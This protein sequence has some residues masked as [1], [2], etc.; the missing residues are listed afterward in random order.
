M[1]V[2]YT[3]KI[4]SNRSLRSSDAKERTV[5]HSM[6]RYSQKYLDH[7]YLIRKMVVSDRPASVYVT[8]QQDHRGYSPAS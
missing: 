7:H 1:D 2:D 6:Q 5:H 3:R 4:S 8:T